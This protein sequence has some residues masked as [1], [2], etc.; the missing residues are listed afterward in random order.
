MKKGIRQLNSKLK[1]T[2]ATTEGCGKYNRL[3]TVNWNDGRKE[4][5]KEDYQHG[6][7]FTETKLLVNRQR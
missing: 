5:K 4:R 1:E 2:G 3:H 6:E 7:K